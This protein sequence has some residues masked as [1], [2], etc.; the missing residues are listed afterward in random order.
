MPPSARPTTLD[1]LRETAAGQPSETVALEALLQRFRERAFGVLLLAATLPA[2]IPLPFGVGAIAGPLVALV[3]LQ[4]LLTF[5]QPWLPGALRRRGPRR[6]TVG[7]FV[8]RAGPLLRRLERRVRPRWEPFVDHPFSLA[9][10]GALL[11]LLGLLLSLPI[12]FTN[13]PFG[14]LLVLFSVALI[15]RDGV[16]LAL[17]WLIGGGTVAG[18]LAASEAAAGWVG[19]MLG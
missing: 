10:T 11:V 3:G 4:L 16:L 2:F 13:Y 8:L 18:F 12:P 19:R 7:R 6:E 1:L 15:E 9:F 17:G 5:K 14:L